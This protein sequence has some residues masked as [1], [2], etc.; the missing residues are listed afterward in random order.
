MFSVISV[1][2]CEIVSLQLQLDSFVKMGA[3]SRN[4]SKA[5]L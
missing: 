3:P 1:P 4:P 2:P 5:L